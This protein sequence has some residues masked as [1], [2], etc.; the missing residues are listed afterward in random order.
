M[1]PRKKVPSQVEDHYMSTHRGT[2]K[3]CMLLEGI[4]GEIYYRS[5]SYVNR[6][7]IWWWAQWELQG[8][9]RLFGPNIITVLPLRNKIFFIQIGLWIPRR[10]RRAKEKKKK[11]QTF[12]KG[13]KDNSFAFLS[14]PCISKFFL[15][16]EAKL[17]KR[18]NKGNWKMAQVGK[19][20][21]AEKQPRIVSSWKL[22]ALLYLKDP[23]PGTCVVKGQ[24]SKMPEHA[25]GR[26]TGPESHSSPL[27]SHLH[28]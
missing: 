26:L 9:E 23:E 20:S 7:T 25:L 14:S 16:K 24:H 8:Q 18:V 4:Y 6:V 22:G 21:R 1:F 28:F 13:R 11:T 5:T 3:V 15:K 19:H 17:E 27:I 12:C 10:G 2:K